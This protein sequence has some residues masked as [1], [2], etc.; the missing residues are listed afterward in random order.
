[1]KKKGRKKNRTGAIS[2]HNKDIVS[3]ILGEHFKNKSLETYG[4]SLPDIV[5]VLPTNLPEITA[6]ELRLDNLFLLGDGSLAII[7]YESSWSEQNK[8]KYL[9]YILRVL[10]KSPSGIRLRMVVIY[11]AD[12]EP[13]Q[14]TAVLDAGCLRM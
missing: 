9:G 1:M 10:L 14:T 11:T 8:L 6:N 13:G 5:D 7:D 12:V 3:K 4:I 2:Y